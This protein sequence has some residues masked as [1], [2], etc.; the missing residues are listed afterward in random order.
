[1]LALQIRVWNEL[2]WEENEEEVRV[3]E[4]LKSWL[5]AHPDLECW[6]AID[7]LTAPFPLL[8]F[9]DL[10]EFIL[11]ES[12][13]SSQLAPLQVRRTSS[14]VKFFSKQNKP[15]LQVC[16]FVFDLI[17]CVASGLAILK[18]LRSLMMRASFDDAI[19]NANLSELDVEA[20]LVDVQ[21]FHQQVLKSCCY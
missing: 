7:S 9:D 8:K 12:I 6:Q 18:R 15:S 2:C 13:L 20:L 5:V 4:L 17:T 19:L 11:A 14:I 1:V 21:L 10:C 16:H 3:R